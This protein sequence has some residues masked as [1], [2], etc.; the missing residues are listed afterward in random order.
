MFSS[1]TAHLRP[2]SP[3][4]LYSF[5]FSH[6][7][8]RRRRLRFSFCSPFALPET[9]FSR[10]YSSS[11]GHQQQQQPYQHTQPNPALLIRSLYIHLCVAYTDFTCVMSTAVVANEPTKDCRARSCVQLLRPEFFILFLQATSLPR[12][13]PQP[14]LIHFAAPSR[15]LSGEKAQPH[16]FSPPALSALCVN[17]PAARPFMA[18]LL[19]AAVVAVDQAAHNLCPAWIF[20]SRKNFH[21]S[22]STTVEILHPPTLRLALLVLYGKISFFRI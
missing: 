16:T 12:P 8:T 1:S 21:S 13:P 3:P 11:T 10:I 2:L 15:L 18:C 22:S 19:S 17:R 7:K 5:T 20:S 6:S 4:T 9:C 14:V